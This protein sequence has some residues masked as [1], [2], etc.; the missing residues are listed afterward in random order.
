MTEPRH[1]LQSR[2]SR[3][4]TNVASSTIPSTDS[5]PLPTSSTK[6]PI[7]ANDEYDV[8]Y[9]P[10]PAATHRRPHPSFPSMR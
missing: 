4:N 8:S 5:L 9:L 6:P 2:P 7:M 3:P 1:R 10:S